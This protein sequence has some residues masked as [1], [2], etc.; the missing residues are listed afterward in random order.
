[1]VT[2]SWFQFRFFDAVK[3]GAGYGRLWRRR[4]DKGGLLTGSQAAWGVNII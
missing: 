1:V 2:E 3:R 4:S